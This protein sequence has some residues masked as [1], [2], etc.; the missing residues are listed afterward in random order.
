MLADKH[1]IV[2]VTGGIAAYKTVELV[3]QL[4]KAGAKAQVIMTRSACEFVAPLTFQ[5]L[6]RN[7]VMTDMFARPGDWEVKHV[8]LA[9]QA[10]LVV[11]APATANIIG[12]AAHGIAD[13]MLSTTIMATTAPVLFA[14]AMNVHMYENPVVQNNIK[15]LAGLGYHFVEPETGRLACGYEGR[16]RLAAVE[17]I[18]ARLAELAEEGR[19][20]VETGPGPVEAGQEPVKA[21]PDLTG[22]TVLVT[23]GPTREAIDPVR[24]ITNAGTG[25]MGY[26]VAGAAVAR[27]AR[28]ILVSGPTDL[29]PPA[30]AELVRVE[31]ALDMLAAVEIYYGDCDVVIKTAAVSDYRPI[32][33]EVR[34]VK[35]GADEVSLELTRNPDILYA[36]GQK[37]GSRI[38]VGFAAETN[39]V[40]QYAREKIM[41]KNLDFIVAN[42]VT[43]PG[44][45]FGTDTNIVKIIC[46]DGQMEELPCLTKNEV[47]HRVLDQVVKFFK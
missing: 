5:T 41:Q 8:S 40:E 20:R 19:D 31:S 36:L 37:K 23:A 42:D 21:Q 45:G 15:L 2:G 17:T 24:F 30:G 25:K 29:S 27:G 6:S 1:I 9:D 18:M 13:D 26:A 12:K 38:L 32:K 4:V 10:D 14:P 3:S 46:R 33:A 47:A 43:I 35:K 28:V 16:G 11:V 34:K 39:D 7:P 44:A 22:K